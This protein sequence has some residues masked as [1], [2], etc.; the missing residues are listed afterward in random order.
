[1]K[2]RRSY[3]IFI[4]LLIPLIFYY[5]TRTNSSQVEKVSNGVLDLRNNSTLNFDEISLNGKWKFYFGELL[6]IDSTSISPEYIDVPG[7]WNRQAI[8]ELPLPNDGFGTYSMKILLNKK[9]VGNTYSMLLKDICTSYTLIIDGNVYANKGKVGKSKEE[10]FP[11]N[12]SQIVSFKAE[13]DEID[14]KILVSNFSQKDSGIWGSIKLFNGYD[15]YNTK[16]FDS[17]LN[18]FIFGCILIVSIY[19]LI[20]YFFIRKD[21]SFLYFGLFSLSFSLRTIANSGRDFLYSNLNLNYYGAF[22]LEYISLPICLYFTIKYFYSLFPQE[23]NKKIVKIISIISILYTLFILFTPPNIYTYSLNLFQIIAISWFVILGSSLYKAYIKNRDGI[24]FLL[25]GTFLL[26]IS[27]F[28]DILV[29]QQIISGNFIMPLGI[30]LFILFQSSVVSQ[31]FS[32]AYANIE[33]YLNENK[34]MYNRIL[35]LNSSLEKKV[36]ERTHELKNKNIELSQM[37]KLDSLTKIYN[38]G[39]I[40]NILEN[41]LISINNGED[42]VAAVMLDI[43]FFKKVNDNYG[44]GCGDKIL[45]TVVKCIKSKIRDSDYLGRY[46]GEEFLLILKNTSL[47]KAFNICERIRIEL[48]KVILEEHGINVTISGGISLYNGESTKE[49]LEKADNN[50]YKAKEL[51]RDRIII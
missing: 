40:M 11:D 38:H 13:R 44:H 17:S 47:D 41:E 45:L 49:L 48:N 10:S 21:I 26:L 19:N 39:S 50:L 24:N 37:A 42:K 22:K 27:V 30:V 35:E 12:S 29:S 15:A 32:I 9:D 3:I 7:L 51:G 25:I 20:Q 28:N 1:M 2:K 36:D 5:N 6:K 34:I 23:F 33:K 4:L 8:R 46:G 14:I 18:F 31:R 16:I 43:D